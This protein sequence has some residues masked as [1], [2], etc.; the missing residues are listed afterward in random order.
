MKKDFF[1]I[2]LQLYI[3]GRKVKSIAKKHNADQMLRAAIL[4]ILEKNTY[5]VTELAKILSTGISAM[6]ETIIDM[7]KKD[8]ILRVKKNDARTNAVTISSK[9]R[10]E[11]QKIM[12]MV[13][14]KIAKK[15]TVLNEE[16]LETFLK[17]LKKISN[18]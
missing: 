13:D 4:M 15:M 5:S 9:G 12:K 18:N 16:E 1:E 7:E 6:S 2:M 14:E 10:G 3:H 11:I 8:F 17:L